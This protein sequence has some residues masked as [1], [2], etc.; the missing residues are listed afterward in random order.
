[1]RGVSR[2]SRYVGHGMRWTLRR[3]A[4]FSP[5]ENAAADGEVVWSWRRD[6]GVY[7]LRL[8]GDGNGD[9]KGR[10]PGR[11]RISRKPLRGESRDVSAVPVK[12]V[13]I[14][15]LL[16]AHGATGAVGARLSLRPLQG[17][18]DDE[19]ARLERKCAAR[20][21][22]CVS[23]RS[24]AARKSRTR[25]LEIPRCAIAHLRFVLRTPRNDSRWAV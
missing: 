20:M 11:V 12:S 23:R 3:Q 9:N 15:S 25:N 14:L 18:R 7:P 2:S 1:M 21:R 13:C 19:S 8:C 4:G 10:S 6:P 24:G 22:T 17:E 5:D 16:F